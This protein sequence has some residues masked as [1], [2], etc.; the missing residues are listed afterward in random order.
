DRDRDVAR[1]YADQVERR[2][3]FASCDLVF[4]LGTIPVAHLRTA[5]P[6]AMWTGATF[7]AMLG[8]YPDYRSLSKT[9]VRMGMD[10]DTRALDKAS[11]AFYSSEWAA[12]SAVE[13]HGAD[14]TKV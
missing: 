12:R 9:A 7:G 4:S 10:L 8:F 1:A 14:V 5:A 13:L 6:L 11:V 3:R 2:L